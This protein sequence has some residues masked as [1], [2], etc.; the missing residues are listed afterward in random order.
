MMTSIKGHYNGKH[1]VP[2]EKITMA[3]GQQVIITILS[4]PQLPSS[5]KEKIDLSRYMG[6][7]PKMF[8]ATD[9][10]DYVRELRDNDRL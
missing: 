5:T 1:I 10:Q 8:P 2:D 3:A 9:A 4:V 6:R 7:G